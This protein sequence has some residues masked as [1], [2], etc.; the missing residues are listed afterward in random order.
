MK[1]QI[2]INEH[3][4]ST[5]ETLKEIETIFVEENLD[6][7]MYHYGCYNWFP[8]EN[9]NDFF[10]QHYKG[11]KRI[12]DKLENPYCLTIEGGFEKGLSFSSLTLKVL[13][14]LY[15]SVEFREIKQSSISL[16]D[17][18]IKEKESTEQEDRE[19]L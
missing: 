12:N 13:A 17:Y 16:Y 2:S 6:F 1:W 5:E 8:E 7:G 3:Y 9:I 10:I 4:D 19:G 18:I 15:I 14:D 11:L